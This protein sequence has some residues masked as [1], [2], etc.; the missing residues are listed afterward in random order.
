MLLLH[1]YSLSANPEE[2]VAPGLVTKLS[3]PGGES[4]GVALEE[5]YLD[6]TIVKEIVLGV[7]DRDKDLDLTS[8]CR[9]YGLD[10]FSSSECCLSLVYGVNLSDNRVLFL[11]CPPTLCR[12]SYILLLC[13]VK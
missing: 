9:R 13:S 3:A 6:L 1:H 4:A 10:R 5:G 7:R 12:Y 8:V 11:L 2:T